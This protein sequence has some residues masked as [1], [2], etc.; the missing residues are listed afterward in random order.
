[1]LMSVLQLT[2]VMLVD[3]CIQTYTPLYHTLLFSRTVYYQD[4]YL[5]A[6]GH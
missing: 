2:Y 1:M 6:N 3:V 4:G 5:G